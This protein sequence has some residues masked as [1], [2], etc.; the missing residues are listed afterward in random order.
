MFDLVRYVNTLAH[1]R[2]CASIF[3]GGTGWFGVIRPCM[4]QRA[5]KPVE[6]REP[7]G[8]DE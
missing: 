2:T 5:V 6:P 4:R 7:F 8:R 1:I 3:L